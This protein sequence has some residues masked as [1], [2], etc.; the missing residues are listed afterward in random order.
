[1]KRKNVVIGVIGAI[2]LVA[3]LFAM[4]SLMSSSASS[5]DLVLN[6]IKL[7]TNYDDPVLRAKA[8]T[9]LNSIVEDIDSSVINEGWRGLAACIP[10]G[11]SDDDYMNFIMSAIVDQPNAIEHSDVL[12]EAIKVHRYWGSNTNVIE[13]SQAL[14]NTNNLI[15]ELHFSTAVNVWNRIVEC[16]GQCEE[17]DNL[18]FE[19]IKVIAE[20]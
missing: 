20:L 4:V 13:F 2:I 15:N 6:V 19:L 8:I 18:F 17:Y 5:K 3:I 10:E 11:C 9:D 7:R 1:M 12:I 14:T 16:N